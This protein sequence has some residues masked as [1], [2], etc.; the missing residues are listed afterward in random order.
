MRS[1]LVVFD[2]KIL[3]CDLKHY[4]RIAAK[5]T[6]NDNF[7]NGFNDPT[8]LIFEK[9]FSTLDP[10]R[11]KLKDECKEMSLLLLSQ[12]T[13]GCPILPH[14]PNYPTIKPYIII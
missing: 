4:A 7:W 1:L 10:L 3:L 12:I 13:P 11:L 2:V 9:K 6:Y 14:V 5:W 8:P